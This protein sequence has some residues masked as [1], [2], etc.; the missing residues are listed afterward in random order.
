MIVI[1]FAFSKIL[2][3][4]AIELNKDV[5]FLV[6]ESAVLN[7]FIGA[8]FL[9]LFII[10]I[11]NFTNDPYHSDYRRTKV[12]LTIVV[13]TLPTAIIFI[14]KG[15][16]HKTIITINKNGI[17]YFGKLKTNWQNLLEAFITQDEIPGSIK[18]NF[19]LI[20]KFYK[21]GEDDCY[22]TKIPLRNT[23]DKSEEEI[24]AA[25]RFFSGVP[26]PV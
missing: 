18:D 15:F 12:F 23:F 10:T 2:I 4:E 7:V 3:M 13:F 17:Y 24:I 14:T 21:D 1:L 11:V 22:E 26:K 6:K 9:L 5:D 25:I 20:L 8:F 16:M 19:V